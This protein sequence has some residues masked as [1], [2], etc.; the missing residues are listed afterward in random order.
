MFVDAVRFFSCVLLMA[1]L[2]L[3]AM[4]QL[5]VECN[6]RK[7]GGDYTPCASTFGSC[8]GENCSTYTDCYLGD[9][10]NKR[11]NTEDKKRTCADNAPTDD[12]SYCKTQDDEECFVSSVCYLDTSQNPDTCVWGNT[13]AIPETGTYAYETSDCELGG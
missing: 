10:G 6:D 11:L 4:S 2:S 1:S 9:T 5:K 13:C 8:A 7:K 12:P 3:T